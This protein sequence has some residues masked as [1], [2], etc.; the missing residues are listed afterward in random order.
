M[1]ISHRTVNICVAPVTMT[2]PTQE[3]NA[4]KGSN[5]GLTM[6]ETPTSKAFANQDGGAVD[7]VP[8]CRISFER[9]AFKKHTH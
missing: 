1:Y 9:F 4:P 2:V 7:E 5:Q 8:V 3:E 6:L